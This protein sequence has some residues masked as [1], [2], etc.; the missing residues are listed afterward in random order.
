MKAKDRRR[1]RSQGPLDGLTRFSLPHCLHV[2]D[3]AGVSVCVFV[4]LR[5]DSV[6]DQMGT[7]LI[8][9]FASQNF[10]AYYPFGLRVTLATNIAASRE[11]QQLQ[12]LFHL[13]S[14]IL[15]LKEITQAREENGKSLLSDCRQLSGG[16][17]VSKDEN[18]RPLLAW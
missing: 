3:C 15:S 2:C 9:D 4:C 14:F 12:G 10:T 18:Q 6:V 1:A 13:N 7:K 17:I 16:R 11:Q 8:R 5:G